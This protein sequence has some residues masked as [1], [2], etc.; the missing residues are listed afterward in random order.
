MAGAPEYL[1]KRSGKPRRS[2]P[3][4]R[5]GM[6]SD[7][8]T[9]QLPS[10]PFPSFGAPTPRVSYPVPS[11]GPPATSATAPA[12]GAA[13]RTGPAVK[14]PTPNF[15]AFPKSYSDP[16]YDLIDQQSA[17]AVGIPVQMLQ[18]VRLSGERSNADQVSSAGARTPYQFTPATRALFLKRGIDPWRSPQEASL[19]AAMHLKEDLDKTGNPLAA[20]AGYNGGPG[21]RDRFLRT[22]DPGNPETRSYIQRV[23]AMMGGTEGLPSGFNPAL[24]G[25]AIGSINA[26]EKAALTPFSQTTERAPMPELPAAPDLP[27]RDFSAQDELIAQMAPK[28]FDPEG[29]EADALQRRRLWQGAAQALASLDD[30]AGVGQILARVGAGILGGRMAADD[31]VQARLDAYDQKMQE[32]RALQY[33]HEGKKADAKFEEANQEVQLAYQRS[34]NQWNVKMQDWSKN[35]GATV[36]G[37]ML[38]ITK[39]NEDGSLSTQGIPIPALTAPQFGMARANVQA[40]MAGAANSA[41]AA[42]A[43]AVSSAI[44]S[45]AGGLVQ[46]DLAQQLAGEDDPAVANSLAAATMAS[47][48]VKY[49]LGAQIA[50]SA[51]VWAALLAEA[52]A[53]AGVQPGMQVSSAQSEQIENYLVG[54]LTQDLLTSP[55][56]RKRV[57]KYAP[58]LT[59]LGR[60]SQKRQVR[61][62]Q[63]NT[64]TTETY[65]ED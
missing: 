51:E 47:N 14:H 12:P 42:Q 23:A 46:A 34:V 54:A 7:P 27:S 2:T 37:N 19:A 33:G 6:A 52:Q 35:N 28:A 59:G 56:T 26:A 49:G 40:S 22:G 10:Y 50:G 13:L 15:A 3:Y 45:T 44:I 17:E 48:A 11:F 29:P 32:Y 16:A 20:M 36:Q 62:R 38:I 1:R 61:R 31:E 25:P 5:P 9:Q 4:V 57:E 8:F 60:A 30:D 39:T 24:Y 41:A 18:A 21:A 63:G 43:A 55:E 64:T 58:A 65:E 53:E